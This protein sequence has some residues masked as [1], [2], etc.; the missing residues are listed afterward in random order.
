MTGLRLL[1]GCLTS[2][3]YFRAPD[4]IPVLRQKVRRCFERSGFAPDS[5][6][7]K[8]L[9]RILDTFP[10]DEL[11]QID[12][13]QLFETAL[14][15]LHLQQRPRIALFVLRDPFERFVTCLVYLPRDR[16]TAEARRRIT[17]IL[18]QAFNGTIAPGLDAI[19]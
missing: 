9:Q 3:S 12:E 16:Y 10:R 11:F 4:G 6:D 7:G 18:E 14:G 2:A 19:R 1:L 5:H 15:I 8:A 17:T 13:Q